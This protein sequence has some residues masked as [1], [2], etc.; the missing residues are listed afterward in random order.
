VAL[1]GREVDVVHVVGGGARNALLCRL[2]AEA[3]G[4]PVVAGP[5]EATAIG[6]LLTQ[7]LALGE[8]TGGLGAV[9]EVVRASSELVTHHPGGPEQPWARAEERLWP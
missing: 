5:V 9:R 1:S 4:L 7:A 3:T 8:L 6:N 2:T